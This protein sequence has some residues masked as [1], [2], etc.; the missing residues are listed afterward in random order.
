MTLPKSLSR[1][2][3]STPFPQTSPSLTT[4]WL[5]KVPPLFPQLLSTAPNARHAAN[6]A[7]SMFPAVPDAAVHVRVLCD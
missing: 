1:L 6:S 3:R 5:V 2:G 7:A 4:C